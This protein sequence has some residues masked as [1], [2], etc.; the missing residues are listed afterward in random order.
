M[1][2]KRRSV[3]IKIWD[4]RFFTDL[5]P[6]EKLFYWFIQCHCDNIGYYSHNPNLAN[7]HCGSTID[8]LSFTDK[9]NRFKTHI[10]I[11]DNETIWIRDFISITW[12]TISGGNNLGLS[13]YTLLVKYDLLDK[14][15]NSYPNNINIPSF[16]DAILNNKKGYSGL[17]LPLP[18]P[19]PS[20]N[21]DS[22]STLL[23]L[24]SSKSGT[25]N[26][27]INKDISNNNYISTNSVLQGLYKTIPKKSIQFPEHVLTADLERVI[28]RSLNNNM[29]ATKEYVLNLSMDFKWADKSWDDF[30]KLLENEFN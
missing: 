1:D 25:I 8:L 20:S 21:S 12:K 30:I 27:S 4:Y 6:S 28:G 14:F 11:L 3:E 9:V 15:I 24:P 10:D 13:C 16:R 19:K 2:T 26:I 29:T 5:D 18:S 22:K 17:P 7:Y 23:G